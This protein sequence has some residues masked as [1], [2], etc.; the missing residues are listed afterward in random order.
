MPTSLRNGQSLCWAIVLLAMLA[1]G[2]TSW[3]RQEESGVP[4]NQELADWSASLRRDARDNAAFGLTPRSRTIERN[5][6]YH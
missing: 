6:G 2:C 4:L 5:L 1:G 3:P